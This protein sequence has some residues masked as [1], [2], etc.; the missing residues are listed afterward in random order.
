V[1]EGIEDKAY[2]DLI[3]KKYHVVLSG[4]KGEAEGKIVRVAHM[5]WVRREDIDEV[6]LAMVAARKE[7]Q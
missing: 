2:R 4:G 7:L 6:I 1:P 3:K 5:G